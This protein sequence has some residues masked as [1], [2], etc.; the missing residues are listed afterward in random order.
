MM[1]A[2]ARSQAP[3]HRREVA[4]LLRA[5]EVQRLVRPLA[6]RVI[7]ARG[8]RGDGLALFLGGRRGGA[9]AGGQG[10]IVPTRA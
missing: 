6:Q 3:D 2:A 7:S 10:L 4:P 9:G 5:V 8:G 1:A